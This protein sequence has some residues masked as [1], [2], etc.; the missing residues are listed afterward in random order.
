VA[1]VGVAG[2]KPVPTGK[3]AR[4]AAKAGPTGDVAWMEPPADLSPDGAEL[5]NVI[6]PDLIAAKVFRAS[7]AVLLS[8][9]VESLAMARG[10]RH[11]INA[12]SPKMREALTAEDYETADAIS[13]TLKRARSGYRQTMQTALAIAGEFGISPVS[14]LRLG[15]MKAQGSTLLGILNEKKAPTR[16]R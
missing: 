16:G 1:T 15:I 4:S 14:R 3:T 11:E 9:L 7:D 10:F 12:L 2:R 13:Q 5:W 6:L 8:E